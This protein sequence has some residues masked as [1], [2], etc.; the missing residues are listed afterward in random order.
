MRAFDR[1]HVIVETRQRFVAGCNFRNRDDE[2]A[3]AIPIQPPVVHHVILADRPSRHIHVP[4]L[5]R[6]D[7]ITYSRRKGTRPRPSVAAP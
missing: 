7:E 2:P 5:G 4:A 3:R 1:N 6:F